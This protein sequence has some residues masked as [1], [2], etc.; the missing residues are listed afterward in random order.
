MARR[1]VTIIIHELHP[2]GGQERATYELANRLLEQGVEL[3]VIAR[4]CE[5]PE[6]DLLR[7]IRIPGPRR[8]FLL[9][10]AWFAFLATIATAIFARGYRQ[11]AGA[12]VLNKLDGSVVH[13]CHQGYSK[14]PAAL[15][16]G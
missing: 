5:L 13:C 14:V 16:R 9:S 2:Y 15:K 8:P 4:R 1:Q 6:S 11:S 10:F 12:I 7:W 3:T